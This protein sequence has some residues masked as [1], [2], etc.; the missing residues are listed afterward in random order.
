MQVGPSCLQVSAASS[1]G[2]FTQPAPATRTRS[3]PLPATLGKS[4]SYPRWVPALPTLRS[5]SLPHNDARCACNPYDCLEAARK[6]LI[7]PCRIYAR[8]SSPPR[9]AVTPPKIA[10]QPSF[11]DRHRA[12]SSSSPAVRVLRHSSRKSRSAPPPCPPSFRDTHPPRAEPR[13]PASPTIRSRDSELFELP[14]YTSTPCVRTPP[15]SRSTRFHPADKQ[16]SV[17]FVSVVS[18][19]QCFAVSTPSTPSLP[20]NTRSCPSPPPPPYTQIKLSL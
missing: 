12:F 17:P 16:D 14:R 6:L 1:L 7:F 2:S 3:R 8:S 13:R 18:S 20:R 10:G 4:F 5:L 15:P 19:L 11:A 9:P